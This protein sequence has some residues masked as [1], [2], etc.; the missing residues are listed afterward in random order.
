M[1]YLVDGYAGTPHITAPQVG[2]YNAGI[3]GGGS[4][5][6]NVGEKLR[7]EMVNANTV[8]IYD[9]CFLFQG[10][11]RGGIQAG[12]YEDVSIDNGTQD[13]K[14]NDLILIKY[15]KDSASQKESLSLA[16]L[17]GTPGASAQD[18]SYSEGDIREGDLVCYM[19][20]YRVKLDGINMTGV[21]KLFTERKSTVQLEQEL[22][23]K[24]AAV[25]G[26]AST[27]TGSNLTANRALVSNGSGKVAVSAVTSTEL[28]YLDGVTSGIQGQLNGKQGT[29]TGGA[30]TITGS[31]LTT[32]RALVSNGSGKVAV[33]AVTS[34]ELGY[35]DGVTSGIQGQLNLLNNNLNNLG[36]IITNATGANSDTKINNYTNSQLYV[37]IVY[38]GGKRFQV[39]HLG[40]TSYDIS[41][42][43]IYGNGNL[44]Y[45]WIDVQKNGTIHFVQSWSTNNGWISDPTYAFTVYQVMGIV[46]K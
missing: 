33:S 23:G 2:D 44:T 12:S 25:T 37:I 42:Y 38:V 24:Q 10:S 45:F 39:F 19:P 36:D 15:E 5:V 22:D 17:K 4:C 1:L 7:A 43:I 14:R 3:T 18:P 34:T 8:R 40:N 30:S 46:A 11:R 16:V 13:Q 26:A 28:G 31:N 9:G 6:F 27:I 21:E 32:N 41:H 20:L 35:L 29:V